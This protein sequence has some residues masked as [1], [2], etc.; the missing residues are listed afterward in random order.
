MQTHK[1]DTSVIPV[2]GTPSGGDYVDRV[3]S[4]RGHAVA[5]LFEILRY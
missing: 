5:Q 2:V 1:I 3:P 4:W